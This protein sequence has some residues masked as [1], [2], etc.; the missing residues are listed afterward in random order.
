MPS[1]V[2][3][4]P[5]RKDFAAFGDEESERLYVFI[6]NEGR[7]V[8]AEPTDFFSDLEASPLVASPTSRIPTVSPVFTSIVGTSVG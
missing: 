3:R 7:L 1:A 2:T 5:A 4:Y 8:N 6:I